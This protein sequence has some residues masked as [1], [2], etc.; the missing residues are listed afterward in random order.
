MGDTSGKAETDQATGGEGPCTT[1]FK[2]SQL[3]EGEKDKLGHIVKEILWIGQQYAV[4]CTEAGV[5]VQF[6]D[7]TS[8]EKTQREKFTHISPELC[9]LRYLTF[10]M[11]SFWLPRL[12]T[13]R[14][15]PSYLYDHNIAQAVMLVMEDRI[16]EG[17]DLAQEALKMAVQRVANDN[18]IR[19]LQWSATTWLTV[20][21]AGA[22]TLWAWRPSDLVVAA[23]FGSTGAMLSV[24]TRLRDFKLQP[25]Q[26]SDMNKL[27]AGTRIVVGLVSGAILLLLATTILKGELTKLLASMEWRGAAVLGL[28]G[29]FAERLVPGLLDRTAAKV[30]PQAGT[31]VQALRNETSAQNA[32]AM[33]DN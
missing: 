8:V 12:L 15:H 4:Y 21:I 3:K 27:M 28:I 9:E 32:P 1:P 18:T 19:Y 33:L 17:Q 23:I 25:C 31:P 14:R 11:R 6:S 20:L 22:I 13:R 26:Q 24:A 29:G 16:K 30:E 5:Y 7:C 2:L 10:E